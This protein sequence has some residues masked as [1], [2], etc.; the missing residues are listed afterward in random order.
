MLLFLFDGMMLSN[1]G[2]MESRNVRHVAGGGGG[3]DAANA[4]NGEGSEC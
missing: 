3:G 1:D 2:R 4:R